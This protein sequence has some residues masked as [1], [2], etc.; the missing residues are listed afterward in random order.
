MMRCKQRKTLKSIGGGSMG[1][2]AAFAP[3]LLHIAPILF[4]KAGGHGTDL[5]RSVIVSN[6]LF[7]GRST[8]SHRYSYVED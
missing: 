2:V 3:K 8:L 1:A 7:G 5:E 6:S 4:R